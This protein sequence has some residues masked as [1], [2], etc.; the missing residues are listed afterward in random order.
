MIQYILVFIAFLAAAVLYIYEGVLSLMATKLWLR[1]RGA[2][3]ASAPH[4]PTDAALPRMLLQVPL[5]NE[6]FV[7]PE[8]LAALSELQYP[9]NKL[10]IQILDDST[11]DTPEV[12]NANLDKLIS[13]GFTVN[14]VRRQNRHGFKAGALAAGMELDSSPFIAIFDADFLPQ[15]DLLRQLYAGFDTPDVGMVQGGWAHINGDENLATRLMSLAIDDHFS[16]EQQG[17]QDANAWIHFNGTAGIWR[18]EAIETSGG[19]QSDCLTEDLDLSFRAQAHG[20]KLKF[21]ED[22]K[23]PCLIPSVMSAIRAQQ[24]RWTKGAAETAV[25]NVSS[26]FSKR[27]STIIKIVDFFHLFNFLMFPAM[28]IMCL[29]VALVLAVGGPGY[30]GVYPVLILVLYPLLPLS[31]WPFCIAGWLRA[32]EDKHSTPTIVA[33]DAFLLLLMIVGLSVQNTISV[34]DGLIGRKSSFV[35]T[36][37]PPR[38]EVAASYASAYRQKPPYGVMALECLV[39]LL[40]FAFLILSLIHI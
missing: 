19:W 16:I 36:P 27:S 23:V 18:R 7:V 32:P 35:R 3:V 8:L 20:W 30:P 1:T 12:V 33:L 24:Y 28:L 34:V 15:P 29:S 17:R 9:K 26:V 4:L 38:G 25:K 6:R 14:H 13:R 31:L 22:I 5:F 21:M 10:L 37:K 40:M 2:P 11:D 39:F